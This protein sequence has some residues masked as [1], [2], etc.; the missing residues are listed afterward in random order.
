M[1]CRLE[2]S[3]SSKEYKVFRKY[4]ETLNQTIGVAGIQIAG[5]CFA[6]N[7]ITT[8]TFNLARLHTTTAYER[9]GHL[10]NGI[11]GAVQIDPDNLIKFIRILEDHPPLDATAKEMKQNLGKEEHFEA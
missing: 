1:A 7:L 6:D 5:A 8:E 11:L 4:F 2:A 3:N 10:L 9:N